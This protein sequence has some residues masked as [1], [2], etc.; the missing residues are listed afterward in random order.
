MRSCRGVSFV[1]MLKL[2]LCGF[3]LDCVTLAALAL[4]SCVAVSLSDLWGAS[5]IEWLL[6]LT[7][8]EC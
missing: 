2:L 4:V 1:A 8:N 3:S 6:A 7:P 5:A